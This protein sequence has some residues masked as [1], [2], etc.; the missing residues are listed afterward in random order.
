MVSSWNLVSTNIV[1]VCLNFRLLLMMM[2]VVVVVMMV[3]MVVVVAMMMPVM[4]TVM[5]FVLRMLF[6]HL[7]CFQRHVAD[8]SIEDSIWGVVTECS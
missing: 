6:L 5:M 2:V 3:V 8:T 4:M 1:L 7:L